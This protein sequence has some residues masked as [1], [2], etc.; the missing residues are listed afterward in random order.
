MRRS[1]FVGA[2][3]GTLSMAIALVTQ[4]VKAAGLVTFETDFV[5]GEG[6]GTILSQGSGGSL[7]QIFSYEENNTFFTAVPFTVPADE[8]SHFHLFDFIAP[9]ATN[10][11]FFLGGDGAGVSVTVGDTSPT[12][13]F[14]LSSLNIRSVFSGSNVVFEGLA[15]GVSTGTVLFEADTAPGIITFDEQIFGDVDLVNIF[16]EDA[17]L[18]GAAPDGAG[19][20]F[21]DLEV[22]AAVPE[23]TTALGLLTAGFLAT[24]LKQKARTKAAKS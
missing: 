20:V 10:T 1:L 19:I 18:G 24:R 2:L 5:T 3:T 13:S 11:D 16:Y 6:V 9:P 14:S 4:P 7:A 23:P 21:D 22:G 15:G 8:P 12:E 17:G